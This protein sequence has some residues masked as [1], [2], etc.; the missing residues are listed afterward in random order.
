VGELRTP[1]DFTGRVAL[2]TGATGGLGPAIVRAFANAG[3]SVVGI[4]ATAGPERV[5]ELREPLSDAARARVRLVAV[6]AAADVAVAQVVHDIQA[7]HGRLD[8]LVNGI[9]GFHAGEPVTDLPFEDWR[10]M[11]DLNLTPAFLFS[12]YAAQAMVAQNWGRIINVSSRAAHSGRRNAAAYATAKN[13]VITLTEAQAEE[14]REAGVT[15][16]V[17]L[18]SIIDT[19]SNRA[20][21]PRADTARW[22]S[23]EQ[24]ARVVLFLASDDAELISGAS[25][26]VYG[27]A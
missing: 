20:A 17:I 1:H 14:L 12:K 27:R 25:I 21:M 22:P 26:P 13:A 18:P 19:P 2:V 6:D 16:N 10:R 24:V 15:V 5:A 4:G 3:A 8:I 23:P 9:G 11:F 7:A